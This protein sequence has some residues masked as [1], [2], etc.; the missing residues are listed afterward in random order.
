MPCSLIDTYVTTYMMV[1]DAMVCD[2]VPQLLI[3][4]PAGLGQH[5]HLVFPLISGP[6]LLQQ[7]DRQKSKQR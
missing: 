6:H 2:E 3:G 4:Q 7:T 5:F 1:T